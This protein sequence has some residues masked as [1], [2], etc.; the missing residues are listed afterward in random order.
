MTSLSALSSTTSEG[1]GVLVLVDGI[2]VRVRPAFYQTHHFFSDC[3]TRDSS[4]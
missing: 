2:G 3:S 1:G 4:S